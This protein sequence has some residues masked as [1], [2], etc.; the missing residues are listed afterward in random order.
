MKVFIALTIAAIAFTGCKKDK[1]SGEDHTF[2][3]TITVTAPA[4]GAVI[5]GGTSFQVQAAITGNMEM[6][7]YQ[8]S[9]FKQADDAL[10]FT[11]EE[12]DHA[13]SF[14]INE[15]V[16]HTLSDTTLLRLEITAAGDHEGSTVT[17]T[18]SFTYVP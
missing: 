11:H 13:T 4:E 10:V 5:N 3:G 7:G 6:H 8:L 15:T 2:E 9:V 1:S 18:V 14:S 17:K 12:H 16:T